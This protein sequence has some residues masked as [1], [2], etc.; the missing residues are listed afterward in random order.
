MSRS[1]RLSAILGLALLASGPAAR[2]QYYSGWGGWGG[3]GGQ[4]PQGDYARGMGVFAAGAGYY[5]ESTAEARSINANTA[6]NWNEYWYQSQQAVNK[7]YYAKMAARQQ[8]NNAAQEQIYLRLRDNP[9]KYDIYRGDA[10][11]VV[12]DQLSSPKV[13]VNGL[14]N[15]SRKFP[16]EMIRDVPFQYASEAVT[17]TVHSIMTK[18]SAPE[19]L[20]K[21]PFR[22]D[23]A[24]LRDLGE[25]IR[26]EDESGD[27]DPETLDGISAVIADLQKKV[28]AGLQAGTKD[29]T[30]ADRF[31]KA[32]M[33][34]T[35]M[36]RTPAINVL[37]SG[38][39]KHPETT[40]GEL[41][42]FMKAFNLRFGVADVPRER[43]VY[44]QLYPLMLTLRDEA[45]PNSPPTLPAEAEGNF[46]QPAEF[47]S[48]MDDK[49]VDHQ[50]TPPPPKPQSSP[51]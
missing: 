41:L 45:F 37:L 24:K 44:D 18:G 19:C 16:G 48:R 5:N 8:Q 50:S 17:A 36:L 51:R 35:K 9:N 49:S 12:L 23:L 31:L 29:R 30:D 40:V 14:K 22:D 10:L 20:K 11:N 2:A 38:V 43:M 39:D 4:T 21:P 34:L 15:A 27:I 28:A 46:D 6:M 25:K 7:K 13:Y 26:Q 33:G 32:A 3:G 1:L 42:S 47:F